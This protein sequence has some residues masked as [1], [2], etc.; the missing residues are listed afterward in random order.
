MLNSTCGWEIRRVKQHPFSISPTQF[1]THSCDSEGKFSI[2]MS[3]LSFIPFDIYL[4]LWG[5]LS[6]LILY[7]ILG[8]NCALVNTCICIQSWNFDCLMRSLRMILCC[9]YCLTLRSSVRVKSHRT[10]QKVV[11]LNK[12]LVKFFPQSGR[13]EQKIMKIIFIK[14]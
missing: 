11:K 7:L 1:T 8:G 9:M 5:K 10:I 12:Y 2:K 14:R 6:S 4:I 13:E 3:A